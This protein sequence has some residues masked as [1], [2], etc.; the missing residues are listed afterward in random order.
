MVISLASLL[1]RGMTRSAASRVYLT[2]MV[3]ITVT[4]IAAVGSE[5]CDAL[6][7]SSFALLGPIDYEAPLNARAALATLILKPGCRSW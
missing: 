4:S 6:V 5:A 1:F 3:L 7:G 2:A